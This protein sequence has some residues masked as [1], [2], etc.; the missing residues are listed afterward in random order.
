MES[1][2]NTDYSSGF[3]G[4]LRLASWSVFSLNLLIFYPVQGFA[5]T[6]DFSLPAEP[7]P[8]PGEDTPGL[9]S[10]PLLHNSGLVVHPDFRFRNE[11]EETTV[12]AV[13][14]GL[15]KLATDPAR[16]MRSATFGAV[17]AGLEA[18]GMY[19]LLGDSIKLFKQATRYRFGTCSQ[20]TLRQKFQLE[21]CLDNKA[22]VTLESNYQFNSLE[23]GL[24]WS[25]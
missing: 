14:K 8:L 15:Y 20:A 21:S 13:G 1:T 24:K 6:F 16:V 7:G 18:V 19:D 17:S 25:F 5:Q 9:Q 10:Q 22:A 4:L 11:Q 23:V 12:D 2:R 3:S